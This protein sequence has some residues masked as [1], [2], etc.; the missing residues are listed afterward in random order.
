MKRA[1]TLAWIFLALLGGRLLAQAPLKPKPAPELQRL[2]YFVGEWKNEGNMKASP[3]GPGGKFTGT[4]HDSMLGDFFLVMH[5]EGTG[6]MGATKD[7]AVMGFDAKEKVYT[8]DGFGTE[9]MHET[10]KGTV[11]GK[12]WTWYSPEEDMGGKKIKGRFI[13]N[14]VSATSYTYSYDTAMDGGAWTNVMEGKATKVK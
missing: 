10:S 7:I 1:V 14:E 9:G 13:L 11:S 8:Y 6:P 12:T 4:D 3:W 5:S 2:H